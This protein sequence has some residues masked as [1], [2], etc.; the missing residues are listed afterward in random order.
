MKTKFVV[1]IGITALLLLAFTAVALAA[2]DSSQAGGDPTGTLVQTVRQATER[3]KDVK[4]AEAAGYWLF[5]GCVS[6]PQEGAMG[7]HYVNGDLVGDGELDATKPEALIYEF[8]NN[9]LQLT[10]VEY[11]VDAATWDA[12]WELVEG[13]EP[14]GSADVI[15]R[16][17]A[18]DLFSLNNLSRNRYQR[19]PV[20]P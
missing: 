11:I 8:K 2:I 13:L 9:R 1:F 10:G 19:S 6:G 20:R 14:G 4:E 7:I 17:R 16:R 12:K 18:S 3:F 5:H 15:L